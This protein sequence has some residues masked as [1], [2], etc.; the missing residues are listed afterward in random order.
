[1]TYDI[2]IVGGGPAGLAF[3]RALDG[4]GLRIALVER[5]SADLLASPPVDGREIAL[6]HRSVATL[7]RLGA[8]AQLGLDDVSPLREAQVLNGG[9]R[10]A[11]AFKTTGTGEDR[12]GH[13]VPNHRIRQVLFRTVAGQ[14]G[15]DLITGLGVTSVTTDRAGARVTLSD[16][17]LLTARLVVAAD[18][19]FSAVRKQLGIAAEVNRLGRSMMICR[20]AHEHDHRGIATEWFDYGQTIA[21]L[22][23]K[24]RL[25]SAVLTLPSQEINRLVALDAEALGAELTRR[26][27]AR[28]G[29]MQV[30]EGPHVYPLATTYARHF[31]ATRAALIGDAAVG[32]HPVTCAWLQP[33]AAGGGGAC[34]TDSWRR[35][36]GKRYRVG[37]AATPVRGDAPAGKPADLRRH[38]P[39]GRPL[40]RRPPCRAPRTWRDAEGG[41]PLAG[42]SPDHQPV[43][44]AALTEKRDLL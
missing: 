30:A 7:T 44:H 26:Y 27:E 25:S 5:Q 23:L 34:G 29:A 12:L 4:A 35:G 37:V 16:G 31:A 11:L 13:L 6:T 15:L 22:P 18:S 41:R 36:Q 32:M 24:D 9:S 21:M 19:R 39:A 14:P 20:V 1:M 8:W 43:P 3:A 10:F 40:Y 28:L 38:Q 2:L 17:R 42:G 33:R